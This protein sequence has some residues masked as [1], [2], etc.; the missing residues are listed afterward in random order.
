MPS[1]PIRIGYVPEHYLLPLHLATPHLQSAGLQTTLVPFPAGTGHMITSLRAREIDLAIGLTEGWVAGLLSGAHRNSGSGSVDGGYRIVGSWCRSPLR[2][3]V[4]TGR[5]RDEI[6]SVADLKVWRRV[7]VSRMGSGSHIMATVLAQREGW[8]EELHDGAG[9]TGSRGKNQ[10]ALEFI[11]LGPFKELRDGVTGATAEN[12]LSSGSDP[13]SAAAETQNKASH[14]TVKAD[15]FMWEHF[16]TKPYFEADDAPL[17]WI[18]EIYTPWPSWHIA[19]STSTFADPSTDETLKSL[20]QA[21]DRGVA[22][23]RA[24][25]ERVVRMLGDGSAKCHYSQEDARE[26]LKKLDFFE[27]T[28]GVDREVMREVVDVLKVAGVVGQEVVLEH[29]GD[30]E[31][32]LGLRR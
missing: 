5:K 1:R 9:E 17:K 25:S 3:A 30:W 11:P 10:S 13:R 6:K 4:V 27:S 18:G 26:W 22:D 19:A 28:K 21:F 23:F 29:D 20:F 2:W 16:T 31:G 24:D 14:S 32:V 12:S 15:F 7:G 8:L